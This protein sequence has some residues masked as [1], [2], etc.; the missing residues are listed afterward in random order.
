MTNQRQDF[1][2]QVAVQHKH[3]DKFSMKHPQ[4][5]NPYLPEQSRQGQKNP[6]LEKMATLQRELKLLERKITKLQ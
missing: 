4:D 3:V 6:T 2:D 1:H 5:E